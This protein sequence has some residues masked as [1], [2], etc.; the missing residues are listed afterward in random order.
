M[1]ECRKPALPSETK[2]G[3]VH[4]PG[5]DPEYGPAEP[6]VLK[7]GHGKGIQHAGWSEFE[8]HGCGAR[9]VAA[10]FPS[11]FSCQSCADKWKAEEERSWFT[12]VRTGERQQCQV[13]VE[14]MTGEDPM[15]VA[16][17]IGGELREKLAK[18]DCHDGC[19]ACIE[20][21]MP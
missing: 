5:N 12:N 6:C 14:N 4:Y 2:C 15:T 10:P 7:I 3:R 1:D 20:A 8:C 18:E 19:P 11:P 17:G 21:A 13:Y 9:P 16:Y